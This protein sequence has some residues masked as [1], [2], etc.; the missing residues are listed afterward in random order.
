MPL[1]SRRPAFQGRSHLSDDFPQGN[2]CQLQTA[3][4]IFQAFALQDGGYHA[5]NVFDVF[6]DGLAGLTRFQELKRQLDSRQR[7]AHLVAHIEQKA[8]PGTDHFP[9]TVGHT[10]E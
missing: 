1:N 8:V 3:V 10:V 7:G 9:D 6:Q 5:F 4:G 2:G